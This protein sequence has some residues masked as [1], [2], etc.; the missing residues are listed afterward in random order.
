M[1]KPGIPIAFN[2]P[3]AFAFAGALLLAMPGLAMALFLYVVGRVTGSGGWF[4]GVFELLFSGVVLLPVVALCAVLLL[5]AGLFSSA[6]PW[7]CLVLLLVNAA[8]LVIAW[9]LNPA[10]D[11]AE[12]VIWVLT[13]LSAAAAAALA[14]Q[15]FSIATGPWAEPARPG[16]AGCCG[17]RRGWDWGWAGGR[18]RRS[19]FDAD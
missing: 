2:P 10:T 19:G 16:R 3:R 6:R 8:V 7:A 13:A 1:L 17:W 11:I 18:R 5:I 12:V 9:M 14:W 4:L 15:A